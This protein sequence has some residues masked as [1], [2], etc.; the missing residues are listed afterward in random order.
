MFGILIALLSGALMSIQ[1][2]FNTQVT[3]QTDLWVSTGWVQLSAFAVC[4][5]AWLFTGRSSISALLDVSPKYML[6]GGV[7][8]A[9]ITVTVIQSMSALGPARSVMLI[10]ISQLIIAYV[11]ELLG[12]FG[13]DKQPLEWRK[14]IG[15][16]VSIVGI[17]IFKW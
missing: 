13:V 8:G 3:K 7:I 2:V 12:M 15:M 17:I 1:G 14:I 9:F 11:I 16:A 10:V 4:I 6:L 5:A